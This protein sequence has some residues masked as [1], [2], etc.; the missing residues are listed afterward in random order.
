MKAKKQRKTLFSVILSIFCMMSLCSLPI[1]AEEVLD[2]TWN[3]QQPVLGDDITFYGPETYEGEKITDWGWRTNGGIVFLGQEVKLSS[4][5]YNPNHKSEA[6]IRLYIITEGN[7]SASVTK[8]IQIKKG[9]AQINYEIF[10]KP[11]NGWNRYKGQFD[12]NDSFTMVVNYSN[13]YFSDINHLSLKVGEV[14]LKIDPSI[15]GSTITIR[16]ISF[17]QLNVL[18]AGQYK[19]RIV[20]DDNEDYWGIDE[21]ID[22]IHI[23]GVKGIKIDS[24]P[25]SIQRGE[26]KQLQAAVD[27]YESEQYPVNQR[28]TWEVVNQTSQDTKLIDGLLTI[29]SDETA[30]SLKVV[31]TSSYDPT[32]SDE[33][34][35]QVVDQLHEVLSGDAVIKDEQSGAWVFHGN[36]DDVIGVSIDGNSFDLNNRTLTTSE[37][38]ME[39]YE[40]IAGTI[41]KGSVKVTLNKDYLQ[42]LAKGTHTIHVQFQSGTSISNGETSFVIERE[43]PPIV[44]EPEKPIVTPEPPIVE[45]PEEPI[46]T[47]EPPI[48]EEPEEPIITP[49]PP[50]EEET[51]KVLPGSST[52]IKN[53]EN[54]LWI[55]KGEYANLAEIT[56]DGIAFD[57][58]SKDEKSA[59]LYQKGYEGV[60]GMVEAGSVKITLYHDFLSTL[61][62]GKHII[63]V[64]FV[65][66]EIE[67]KGETNFIL[68]QKEPPVEDDPVEPDTPE[69]PSPDL[70]NEPDSKPD[71]HNTG[72]QK[73]NITKPK[74]EPVKTTPKETNKKAPIKQTAATDSSN[75]MIYG[76]FVGLIGAGWLLWKRKYVK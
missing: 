67:T 50:M 69:K 75:S 43:E 23:Y 16:P 52:T 74:T 24:P 18:G 1:K 53:G 31:A 27:V 15:S 11:Q 66:D 60:A 30:S 70:P 62:T 22:K 21:E 34:E 20:L 47:P 76:L 26:S 38:R 6:E 37:L 68:K 41:E 48:V 59:M 61:T 33:I 3:P 65:S 4:E 56:L 44:E 46:V 32:F 12:I 19:F 35:I 13:Y 42:T 64:S 39:G 71:E 9:I 7:K 72:T 58:V 17:D 45:E 55:F 73:E 36:Y 25:T 51:H 63:E 2:F 57:L 54:G 8:T 5:A 49:E 29:G 14:D 40:G 10:Y 28:V